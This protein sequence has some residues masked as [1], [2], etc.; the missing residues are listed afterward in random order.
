MRDGAATSTAPERPADGVLGRCAQLDVPWARCRAARLARETIQRLVLG[1]ILLYYT[2]RRSE[3]GERFAGVRPPVIFVAN[4][5]S[6]LDTPIVLRALPWSWRHRTAVAAA[7]DYFYRDRRVARLVSLVFNTVPVQRDGGGSAEMAH[8]D[9]LLEGRWNLLVYPEG[10]R[11]REGA[12]GRLRTGAAVLAA[13]HG[14]P[15]MPIHVTGTR[16]AMPPGQSWPRRRRRWR[17]H[18]VRVAFGDPIWPADPGE[19]QEVTD[20]VEGFFAAA[21]RSR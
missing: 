2:R 4:H 3:G 17:R 8:V 12:Q 5:R 14:L 16:A 11:A 21:G 15:V 9:R 20:A 7:A 13:R 10:T 6:H 19:R 18:P 1:P